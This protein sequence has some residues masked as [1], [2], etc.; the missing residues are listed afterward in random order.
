MSLQLIK[1]P[2]VKTLDELSFLSRC[3][4]G[5]DM[6]VWNCKVSDEY[7]TETRIMAFNNEID[8]TLQISVRCY[9]GY[10][11]TKSISLKLMSKITETLS[12]LYISL[13][14][15]IVPMPYEQKWLISVAY[16]AN[17]AHTQIN[18]IPTILNL[19]EMASIEIIRQMLAEHE[20]SFLALDFV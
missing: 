3:P 7:V 18:S 4:H 19:T 2:L 16:E 9:F 6:I 10:I 12:H 14:L 17:E 13:S 20:A 8:K 11:T 5:D 15:K 1:H